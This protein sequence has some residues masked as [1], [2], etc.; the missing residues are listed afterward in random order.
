MMFSCLHYHSLPS[1]SD[2]AKHIGRVTGPHV[3]PRGL[4]I[5][6]EVQTAGRGQFDR[7]WVSLPGGVYVSY[8][9]FYLSRVSD[10][11]DMPYHV[12]VRLQ[13]WLATH[14]DIVCAVKPPNDLL[15]NGKKLCGI[16]IEKV[17]RG[18]DTFW[19]LGVG[20]NLN[21]ALFPETVTATSM[22]IIT[23][24]TYDRLEVVSSLAKECAIWFGV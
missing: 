1:T 11:A 19:V 23:G 2:L 22:H 15:V 21:Q 8:L 6:A 9:S 3:F 17:S 10:T 18:A 4:C 16:L 20:L 12:G 5:S 7:R 14:Y 13:S 24:K